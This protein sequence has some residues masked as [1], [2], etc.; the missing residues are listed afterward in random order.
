MLGILDDGRE[1]CQ[2]DNGHTSGLTDD[3]ELAWRAR[4]PLARRRLGAG[5]EARA[6]R[7][8]LGSICLSPG[9]TYNSPCNDESYRR[10]VEKAFF[11]CGLRAGDILVNTFAYHVSP[12]G[13]LL[14]GPLRHLG[15]AV[16]P[17][18]PGNKQLQVQVMKELRATAFTGTATF[19][20]EILQTAEEM[21]IDP[22]KELA[23][24]LAVTPLDH[25]VMRI[26]ERDYGI[27]VT[28]F[29]GTADVG[30]VAYNCEARAGMHVCEEVIEIVDLNTGRALGPGEI[31][32]V[33]LTPLDATV[34]LVRYAPGDLSSW[35]D[36]TCS[37]GRTSARLEPLAGWIG[38][39]VKRGMF[40]H[41]SQLATVMA[42][43][44]AVE[45]YR[46]VCRKVDRRDHL[47]LA[48]EGGEARAD[49]IAEAL[50]RK[51]RD[52]CRVSLDAIER[53]ASGT[54]PRDGKIIVDERPQGEK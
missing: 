16:V 3:A 48:Y 14:D 24:R 8:L 52:V 30:I 35:N 37:C 50:G 2:A 42:S 33:V 25:G 44:R 41:P 13:L 53:T 31:G 10:R 19:L 17:M 4:S 6:G 51:F 38:Q 21:G 39:A 47:T 11:G 28:E 45:V 23:L 7:L 27:R 15:V 20:L 9:P 43:Q 1:S 46:H 40:V 29:Y 36:Q 34:P 22:R 54:I 12:M 5:S 49:E 18:G 26:V 32:R